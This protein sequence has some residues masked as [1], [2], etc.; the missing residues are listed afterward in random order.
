VIVRFVVIVVIVVI[1]GI[2]D[3]NCLIFLF[4]GI[5]V[6]TFH[7]LLFFYNFVAIGICG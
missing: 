1:V 6:I 5:K 3:H 7:L 4:I 2:I